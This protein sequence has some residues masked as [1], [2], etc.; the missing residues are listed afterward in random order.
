MSKHDGG[1][2]FGGQDPFERQADLDKIDD[3]EDEL[4]VSDVVPANAVGTE[5]ANPTAMPLAPGQIDL[6]KTAAPVASEGASGQTG[7]SE[8]SETLPESTVEAFAEPIDIVAP[9]SSPTRPN[10]GGGSDGVLGWIRANPV[11]LSLIGTGVGLLILNRTRPAAAGQ[12]L[13]AARSAA[14]TALDATRDVASKGAHLVADVSA[15][16]VHR[17]GDVVHAVPEVA[18]S[19]ARRAGSTLEQAVQERPLLFGVAALLV[20]AAVALLLPRTE[21]ENRWFGPAR[22]NLLEQA[23]QRAQ[24]IAAS[25]QEV[26]KEAVHEITEQVQT[27]AQDL[28]EQ[29]QTA[30]HDLSES[31]QTAAHDLGDTVQTVASHAVDTL[32][33]EVRNEVDHPDAAAPPAEGPPAEG[34]PS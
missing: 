18:G 9:P 25:A 26:A 14:S 4:I 22:D 12:A 16:G 2:R 15:A 7:S 30:A 8:T 11:P 10:P 21:N 27:T 17:V 24:S 29:V 20:G 28:R 33:E 34:A 1:V 13:D 6:I 32:K 5:F 23:R 31:V 3:L 19:G